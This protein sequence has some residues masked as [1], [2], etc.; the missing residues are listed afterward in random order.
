MILKHLKML[1]KHVTKLKI[2]WW[3]KLYWFNYIPN[4][5]WGFEIS[6]CYRL[7]CGS[8]QTF[9]FLTTSS[10]LRNWQAHAKA[11][12]LNISISIYIY[13]LNKYIYDRGL[14]EGLGRKLR[15]ERNNI[16]TNVCKLKHKILVDYATLGWPGNIGMT[17]HWDGQATFLHATEETSIKGM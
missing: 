7:C 9:P 14:S 11:S 3:N 10:W 15:K 16:Y 4:M 2:V 5:R 17:Q 8:H 12:S 6:V 13:I 1:V